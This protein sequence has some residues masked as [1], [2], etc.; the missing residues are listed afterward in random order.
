MSPMLEELADG[1]LA[2]T[3]DGDPNVGAVI[4]RDGILAI[5]TRATPAA[6]RPWLAELRRYTA[7]PVRHLVLTHYHAVR[8]LG[9]SAFEAHEIIASEGTVALIRERGERDWASEFGRFPHLT[10]EPEGVPGLTVP[11]LSF[12]DGL[13]VSLGDRDVVIRFAGRGHTAGDTVVWLPEE[14]VLFSGDLVERG[15]TPYLGDAYPREWA[16]PTLDRVAEFDAEVLLPGRGPAVRGPAVRESIEDTRAFLL[17][18]LTACRA[19]A[20]RGDDLEATYRAARAALAPRY[21][22]WAIFEHCLPFNTAR[23]LDGFAGREPV[24]WTVESDAELRARLRPEA[25]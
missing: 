23:V 12:T 4:G 15:A 19:A 13:T 21:G 11:T 5:D 18:L 9:A 3:G 16:G 25:S 1:V 6:A 17:D 2:Y 24:I 22:G 7:K 20:D 10:P 8:V 14:K